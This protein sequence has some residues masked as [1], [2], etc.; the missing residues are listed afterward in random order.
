MTDFHFLSPDGAV[1]VTLRTD[2]IGA[3]ADIAGGENVTVHD[4]IGL[5]TDTNHIFAGF[6]KIKYSINDF[7][8]FAET[9]AMKLVT[10]PISKPGIATADL[11]VP[12]LDAPGTF[13]ATADSATQITLTWVKSAGA[14]GY[15][16]DRATDAGFTAN[17]VSSTLGDVATLAV[18]GL[19]TATQYYFRIKATA[20]NATASAYRTDDAT[21]A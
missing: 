9:N 4:I 21:T 8:A 3:A 16:V 13:V 1:D 14:T 6:Q 18:T 11:K 10:I 7:K 15:V 12:T 20:P 19:T 2:F 5:D 17:L